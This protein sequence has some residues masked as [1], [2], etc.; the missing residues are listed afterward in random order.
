MSSQSRPINPIESL[1]ANLNK[2]ILIKIKRNRVFKGV[3]RSF[4]SHLNVML[5]N[6]TYSYK[7]EDG[8]GNS[9]DKQEDFKQIVIRGDN[10]V[11]VGLA[12]K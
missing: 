12:E 7:L 8:Q 1:Y 9:T 11:F 2:E 10:I 5:E 3:L 4:D 6:C